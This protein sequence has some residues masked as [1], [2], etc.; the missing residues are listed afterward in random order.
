MSVVRT[1]ESCLEG[2]I[3]A[4]HHAVSNG[5]AEALNNNIKILGRQSRGYR[6]IERYKSSIFFHFGRL[7]MGFH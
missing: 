4:M 6:N 3:N 7:D 2:I 1:I 5:R